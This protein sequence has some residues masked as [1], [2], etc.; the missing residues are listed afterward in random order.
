M[1]CGMLNDDALDAVAELTGLSFPAELVETMRAYPD[2][3]RLARLGLISS[4][5]EIAEF[6]GPSFSA[7]PF[8]GEGFLPFMHSN[9]NYVLVGCGRRFRGVVAGY[10]VILMDDLGGLTHENALGFVRM[11]DTTAGDEDADCIELL[12]SVELYDVIRDERIITEADQKI[13][14]LLERDS[15]AVPWY[16]PG[17]SELTCVRLLEVNNFHIQE[18]A[19]WRLGRFGSASALGPVEKLAGSIVPQGR[20]NQHVR[21]AMRAAEQI[22][23]R[24]AQ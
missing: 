21:T 15:S 14:E 10:G 17:A 13:G 22:K 20:V 16:L 5:H 1:G 6:A 18:A 12:S 9:S 11:L 24:S 2:Q 4:P 7:M 3:N 8:W 19:A 23:A